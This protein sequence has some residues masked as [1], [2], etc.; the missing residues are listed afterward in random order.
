MTP[1]DEHHVAFMSHAVLKLACVVGRITAPPMYL[2]PNPLDLEA[3][4][5]TCK[6][7]GCR[8]DTINC[9]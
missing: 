9:S 5:V 7:E 8:G 4:H 2:D 1:G 3:C 6:N